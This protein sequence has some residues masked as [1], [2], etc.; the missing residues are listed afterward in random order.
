MGNMYA[1]DLIIRVY[2]SS[3]YKKNR[4]LVKNN[5]IS[6]VDSNQTSSNTVQQILVEENEY[7]DNRSVMHEYIWQDSPF[8]DI[9]TKDSRAVLSETQQLAKASWIEHEKEAG[10][11]YP[12]WHYT[13]VRI[14]KTLTGTI[15]EDS[16]QVQVS[17]GIARARTSKD[18][19]YLLDWDFS[20]RSYWGT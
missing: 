8:T 9:L 14:I 10:I 1:D 18:K 13:R 16:N 5:T 19:L 11:D 3:F 12:A 17:K 7:N 15:L 20:M 4:T 2:D 6:I